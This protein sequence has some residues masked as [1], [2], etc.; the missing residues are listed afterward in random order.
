MMFP[1]Q[2]IVNLCRP[3]D[4]ANL[5]CRVLRIEGKLSIITD[6]ISGICEK[7]GDHE[8]ASGGG[9]FILD[10]RVR[11]NDRA[12][13]LSGVLVLKGRAKCRISE[14]AIL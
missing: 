5:V 2:E 13:K 14:D 3:L 1:Q 7:V 8:T 4:T 11:G 12:I 9:C 6:D 10:S